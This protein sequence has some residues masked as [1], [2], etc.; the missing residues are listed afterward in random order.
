LREF[1]FE[2]P[3]GKI[4]LGNS[5]LNFSVIRFQHFSFSSTATASVLLLETIFLYYAPS[6]KEAFSK[7]KKFA[8]RF[9]FFDASIVEI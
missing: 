2:S 6:L 9:R 3:N 8:P 7:G 4:P 1:N 5:K